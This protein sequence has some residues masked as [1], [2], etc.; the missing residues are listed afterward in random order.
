MSSGIHAATKRRGVPAANAVVA[1]GRAI[2]FGF[3]PALDGLRALSVLG[4]MMYHGGA[5]TGGFLTIDVF[6]VLSGLPDH[7][8]AAR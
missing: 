4:V 3:V 7:L 1:R 5:L 2:S 8:A 6:F